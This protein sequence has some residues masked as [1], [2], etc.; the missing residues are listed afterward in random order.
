LYNSVIEIQKLNYK[1]N[2]REKLNMNKRGA[3]K[4]LPTAG[5]RVAQ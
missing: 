2:L 3:A 5:D 1:I 4:Y